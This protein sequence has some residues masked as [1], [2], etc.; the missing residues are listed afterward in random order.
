MSAVRVVYAFILAPAL[1]PAL[2]IVGALVLGS[3]AG[4]GIGLVT[5]A[6]FAYLPALVLGVPIYLIA[7]RRGVP[8]TPLRAGVAGMAIAATPWLA[9]LVVRLSFDEAAQAI[10][11]F[12]GLA[13]AC[14]AVSGGA[15]WAVAAWPM[16]GVPGRVSGA[17]TR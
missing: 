8:L 12:A 2:W 14:G 13:G 11:L 9:A 10:L 6:F 16:T 5:L 7:T 15:F 17:G 3:R 1:L 4:A